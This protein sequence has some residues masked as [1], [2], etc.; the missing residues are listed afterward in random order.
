MTTHSHCPRETADANARLPELTNETAST[1]ARLPELT[2]ETAGTI[3][4]P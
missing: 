3:A 2:N 4:L 1:I